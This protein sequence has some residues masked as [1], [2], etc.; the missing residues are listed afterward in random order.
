[1][2]QISEMFEDCTVFQL[3]CVNFLQSVSTF[4]KFT[5]QSLQPK[6]TD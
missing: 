3:S 4:V 1:M 2:K 5:Q 6:Q